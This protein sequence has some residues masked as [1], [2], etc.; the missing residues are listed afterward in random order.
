MTIDIL[1]PGDLSRD[2]VAAW[3]QLQD[4]SG[5]LN[6]FF[7]PHWVQACA[8]ATGPDHR[9]AKVAVL[10]EGGEAVGFFPAR[11]HRGAAIP[12][13]APMCDYQGMV[14]KPGVAFCPR[15]IVRALRVGRLDFTSLV[16]DQVPFH[17]Y[18]RGRHESQVINLSDGYDAYA[19]QRRAAGTDILQDTAKKRRK[20]E[21]EH[22]EITFGALSNAQADFDQLFVWKRAQYLASG[23][24]D[25]FDAGWTQ[26]LLQ[27]LFERPAPDF[28]GAF[29]TLYAGGKLA[30]AHFAL[31]QN[32]V[33]HAWFIAHDEAFAKYSPGVILINDILKWAGEAGVSE[34]DLG[35]GDYRF[36]Q[37]LA[38]LKRG[39]AHGYV[40]RPSRATFLREAAYQ[41]RDT[42]EAL[43]LG[44]YSALPG[45]AMRRLD[46][47]RSL[48]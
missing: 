8:R 14:A 48:G 16:E 10:R 38:N 12:V 6:P 32:G 37:S 11:V 28:G 24:T 47:R 40:G 18:M 35:P 42:F 45:K 20:L 30:A 15:Q 23:Q 22:G 4:Q 43:P 19:A 9:Q 2:D 29:F 33:L 3:T 44:R 27:D 13:G 39:V 7:S 34:L 46:L 21:R 36:K 26:A 25:I 17:S 41:V 5:L 31:R 1:T